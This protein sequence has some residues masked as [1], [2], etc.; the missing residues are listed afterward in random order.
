MAPS[1]LFQELMFEVVGIAEE[2]GKAVMEIYF[3]GDFGTVY[4]T[5]NSPVTRADTTSHDIIA[6]KLRA[7]TPDLPVLS[8]E[9]GIE[10]Y[11]KRRLWNALW[12]ID[13]LDG[14]KEFIK[15]NGEFTVNIAL[16]EDSHPVLGV[17]HAPALAVSYFAAYGVGAFKKGA[18]N[19]IKRILVEPDLHMPLKVVTSRSHDGGG[20]ERLFDQT[21]SFERIRVGSS[22]KFCLVAEGVAHLYPR[23]GPTMEWD[24]AAGQCV[25]E[26][27]GGSVTDLRGGN[28]K[29]NK[30][31]L[32]NPPFMV[33][34]SPAS[35]WQNFLKTQG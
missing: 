3:Q 32:F 4:K 31:D 33:S 22:L 2:A 24:T 11:V 35:S 6:G 17:V 21:I 18:D 13:P 28:L 30:L 29:Y 9:S 34:C 1:L 7:L 16:I 8:E 15:R 23:L 19:Q 10:P 25:V 14:T 12:L 26:M 5:D 27:A 20:L